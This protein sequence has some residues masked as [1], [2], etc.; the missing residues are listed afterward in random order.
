[1][2]SLQVNNP[3]LRPRDT[4]ENHAA[5]LTRAISELDLKTLIPRAVAQNGRHYSKE[6]LLSLRPETEKQEEHGQL[7]EN[8]QS[9]D[10]ESGVVTPADQHSRAPPPTPEERSQLTKD[11]KFD[12]DGI[13]G[14]V[15]EEREPQREKKKKKN[16]KSSGKN[17]KPNPTGFEGQWVHV[18]DKIMSA[19]PDYQSSMQTLL[20]PRM[21]L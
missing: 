17:K 14:D 4:M 15:D 11:S 19:H 5:E 1:M 10:G 21:S 9:V 20:L 18:S 6:Q 16:K 3:Y 13:D 7:A 12:E 8:V 2:Q